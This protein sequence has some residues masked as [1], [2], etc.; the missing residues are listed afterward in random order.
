MT[1]TMDWMIPEAEGPDAPQWAKDHVSV[2]RARA[3]QFEKQRGLCCYCFEPMWMKLRKKKRP[4]GSVAARQCTAEHIIPRSL[5]GSNEL[6]NIAAACVECNSERG[7]MDA[8]EYW[9][10]H[11]E[12]EKLARWRVE[13]KQANE[14]VK[15]AAKSRQQCRARKRLAKHARECN[16]TQAQFKEAIASLDVTIFE[17]HLIVQT[18]PWTLKS[19]CVLLPSSLLSPGVITNT[20]PSF[21]LHGLVGKMADILHSLSRQPSLKLVER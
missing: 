17:A 4:S 13:R 2:N 18:R 14:K 1:D 12:P 15:R 6:Q 5:G 16:L 11:R 7:I 20:F 10:L 8:M 21:M 3:I 9:D 19:L